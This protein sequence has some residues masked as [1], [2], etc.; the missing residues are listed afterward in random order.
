MKKKRK[1]ICV[2][3]IIIMILIAIFIYLCTVKGFGIHTTRVS[4]STHFCTFLSKV[5]EKKIAKI[6][7]HETIITYLGFESE[8]YVLD[9]DGIIHRHDVI[10]VLSVSCMEHAYD[11]IECIAKWNNI[12]PLGLGVGISLI[13]ITLIM[14]FVRH[15]KSHNIDSE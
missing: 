12:I 9:L 10:F 14:L 2:V 8:V 7:A 3:G 11:T 4:N 1:T 15:M 6:N 13:L 5:D